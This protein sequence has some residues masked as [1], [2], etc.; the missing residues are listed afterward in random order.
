MTLDE[1]RDRAVEA[2]REA[3]AS[4]RRQ[5]LRDELADALGLGNFEPDGP[6]DSYWSDTGGE[7]PQY[8]RD[9]RDSGRGAML[10]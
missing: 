4:R 7:S 8:R 2:R 6:P 9:M 10:R 3:N 1:E 5:Y